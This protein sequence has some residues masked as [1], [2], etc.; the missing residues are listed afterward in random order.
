MKPLVTITI[1]TDLEQAAQILAGV[2]G[3][4]LPI[5]SGN[6]PIPVTLTPQQAAE[7]FAPDKT[8]GVTVHEEVAAEEAPTE[9]GF[10]T[11]AKC[12]KQVKRL[13][14][15]GVHCV[16]CNKPKLVS[17]GVEIPT[18]EGAIC[19]GCKQRKPWI[20]EGGYCKDCKQS[21]KIIEERQ[22]EAPIEPGEDNI[23]IY[24]RPEAEEE[25]P[26]ATSSELSVPLR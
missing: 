15:D 25:Q 3:Y 26:Q 19:A 11:C 1:Q 4:E 8:G 7:I 2:Q 21:D 18:E 10:K 22:A 20:I 6:T 9:F 17:D 14:K 23:G 24:Q 12:G 13:S 16:K 5:S